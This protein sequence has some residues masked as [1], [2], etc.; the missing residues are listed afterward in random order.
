MS[1][2]RFDGQVVVVTGAAGGLGSAL[3]AAFAAEGANVVLAGR[4]PV[5]LKGVVA[6]LPRSAPSTLIVPADVRS[7]ADVEALFAAV[8]ERFGRLDVLVNNGSAWRLA[9]T[10]EL[11]DDTWDEVIGTNLTGAW[12]CLKGAVPLMEKDG[13]GGAITSVLSVIGPHVAVPAT[14]AYGAAKA[15]VEALSR[16]G[17]KEYVQRG[18]RVNTVSPGAFDGP[19]SLLDGETPEERQ[20]RLSTEI[21]A[22]RIGT[23]DEIV[24][25]V[26]WVSS[27]EA[28]FVV[29]HDLVA[30]GGFSA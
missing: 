2:G 8:D 17:A 27:A 30:D 7:A 3:C 24:A 29:G 14:G 20:E 4:D 9:L 11:D 5:A 28:S 19:M 18:I 12:R 6:S 21:P 10:A 22:G 16:T 23:L 15:G 25:C 26:L 13:R 1:A